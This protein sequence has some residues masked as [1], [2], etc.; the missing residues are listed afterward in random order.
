MYLFYKVPVS[1]HYRERVYDTD[2]RPP[3]ETRSVD[4]SDLGAG[5]EEWFCD[6]AETTLLG[7]ADM[8]V[9]GHKVSQT[10]T[11]LLLVKKKNTDMVL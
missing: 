2:V 10:F 4:T 11:L 9:M 5:E 1:Y 3:T 6:E 7:Y 8:E